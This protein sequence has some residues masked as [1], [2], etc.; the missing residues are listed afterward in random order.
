MTLLLKQLF[1]LFKMLNSDQ[2]E[3]SIA[4]G[5]ALGVILGF[6]PFISL[7]F[8]LVLLLCFFFRIQLGA[9]FLS[10]FF[11]KLIAWTVGPLAD[12]L[13]QSLLE[14][15][16]LRPL[17]TEMY[18]MPLLPMTRFNNSVVMGSLVI[19]ILLSLPLFFIFKKMILKYR[20]SFIAQYKES[21]IWKAFAATKFY[22]WYSK[23]NEL[24]G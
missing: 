24:Y 20:A 2:G 14:N 22:G 5:L 17:L 8:L 23:Y 13:G 3:N 18:N 10:A 15:E 19:S 12:I 4:A 6:A 7:Q 16:S 1:A 11:F 21:K 9:A